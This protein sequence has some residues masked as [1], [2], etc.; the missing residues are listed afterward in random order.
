MRK[1]K[2]VFSFSNA[3]L[4]LFS[5]LNLTRL[6]NWN[7]PLKRYQEFKTAETPHYLIFIAATSASRFITFLS[8]SLWVVCILVMQRLEMFKFFVS[9]TRRK[10]LELNKTSI[11][12]KKCKRFHR[13]YEEKGAGKDAPEG[14]KET[15]TYWTR[16]IPPVPMTYLAL[17]GSLN[18]LLW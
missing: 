14:L 6:L 11:I 3:S 15:P 9:T 13:G 17:D 2:N 18:V 7:R 16:T 4:S 1:K 5:L 10:N 8:L 12:K